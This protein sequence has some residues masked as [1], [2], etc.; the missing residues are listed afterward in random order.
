VTLAGTDGASHALRRAPPGARATVI[1]FFSAHCPCQRA[2]DERLVALASRYGPSGVAF[3]AVDSEADSSLAADVAEAKAR[4]LPFPILSD[5]T[6]AVANAFGAQCATYSVLVDTTGRILYRGGID[7]DKNHVHADA[8]PYLAIAI[9]QWLA[10]RTPDPA[11]SKA[12][13]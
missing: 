9:D 1:T 11:E 4:R 3:L 5:P 13:G 7:S 10:G 2:H 8:T 12:F 6:G